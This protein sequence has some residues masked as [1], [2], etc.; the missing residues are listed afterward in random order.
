[1]AQITIKPTQVKN[2]RIKKLIV[3]STYF[4]SIL[5]PFK[6]EI[7]QSPE[8]FKIPTPEEREKINKMIIKAKNEGAFESLF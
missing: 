5:S 8:E 4:E 3:N 1:M 7:R 2:C 6:M